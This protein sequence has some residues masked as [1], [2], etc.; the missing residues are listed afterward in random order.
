M[1]ILQKKRDYEQ[2]K[3]KIIVLISLL[4]SC[5]YCMSRESV[6]QSELCVVN[7]NYNVNWTPTY[8]EFSKEGKVAWGAMEAVIGF[9]IGLINPVAGLA[10]AL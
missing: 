5:G 6:V 8:D 2:K 9:G 1:L 4:L 3:K 10:Y 7:D